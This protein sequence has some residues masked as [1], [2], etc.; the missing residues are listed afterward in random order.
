VVPDA[1]AVALAELG[2][3]LVVVAGDCD[4]TLQVWRDG[5]RVARVDLDCEFEQLA[6]LSSGAIVVGAFGGLLVLDLAR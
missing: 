5:E 3:S 1:R 2:G 4:G 6:V